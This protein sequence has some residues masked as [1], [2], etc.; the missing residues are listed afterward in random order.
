MSK[1]IFVDD[2]GNQEVIRE[3]DINKY[4]VLFR[5]DYFAT[6]LWCR[7]DIAVRIEDTYNSYKAT[8]EE[9][10]AVIKAG[11]NWWGL[12]DC[13]DGEWDCIDDVIYEVL[14]DH[15]SVLNEVEYKGIRYPVFEV[16]V[17][18]EYVLVANEKLEKALM[19]DD[20]YVDE[21]AISIDMM[22]YY[23]VSDSVTTD[24]E[25]QKEVDENCD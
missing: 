8:D 21:E 4:D 14:G 25:A 5:S 7:E 13:N 23:Y 24:E 11:G 18:D 3:G 12:N 1:V 17:N 15:K 22:I 9:I 19:P 10:D 6:K 2:N 20:K 16:K